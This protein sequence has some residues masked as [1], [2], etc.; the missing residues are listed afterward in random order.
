MKSHA[1]WLF[2][3]WIRFPNYLLSIEVSIWSSLTT[4]GV[5]INVF[6][7]V[8]RTKAILICSCS[9]ISLKMFPMSQW[10][11]CKVSFQVW[12]KNPQL[13]NISSPII[14]HIFIASLIHFILDIYKVSVG[15]ME[16]V[17]DGSAVDSTCN[18]VD[19]VSI[20]GSGRFLGEGNGNQLQYSCR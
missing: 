20:P 16:C 6:I 3:F 15:N 11:I 12:G 14:Q 7:S 10:K 2:V 17:S 5:S 19:A 18:A 4:G 9:V 1:F 8:L 13:W